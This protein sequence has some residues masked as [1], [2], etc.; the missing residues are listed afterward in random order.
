M[1]DVIFKS[2]WIILKI[3]YL[4]SAWNSKN[5][6]NA[7]V[8]WRPIRIPDWW[9]CWRKLKKNYQNWI[10]EIFVYILKKS[11]LVFS[12]LLVTFFIQHL[13][14]YREWNVE[15]CFQDN[16]FQHKI[17]ILLWFFVTTNDYIHLPFDEIKGIK[18]YS[19]HT[20]QQLLFLPL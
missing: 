3:T 1:I 11:K 6:N 18:N 4:F 12:K 20:S 5:S 2:Y 15:N 17:V 13:T 8:I 19:V 14:L 16:V 9:R 7:D 10:W